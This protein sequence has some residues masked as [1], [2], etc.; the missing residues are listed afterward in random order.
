MTRWRNPQ[1]GKIEPL[2]HSETMKA[3][4]APKR[5]PDEAD[6]PPLSTFPGRKPKVN[7][8]QL[9]LAQHLS[10]FTDAE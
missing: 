9:T 3:L 5:K 7:P 6:A 2:S 1:T 4:A 10:A 8:D